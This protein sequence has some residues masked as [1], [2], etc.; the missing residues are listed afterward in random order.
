MFKKIAAL[1]V[2]AIALPAQAVKIEVGAGTAQNDF[3]A[4]SHDLVATI[5]Y[6]AL[7]PAEATGIT[8][9]GVGVFGTY[10]GVDDKD[11]WKDVT[12]DSVDALGLVGLSATKG[13]PFGI[14]VG[15]FYTAIPQ[16]DVKVYG[17]EIRYAFLEG[18]A[19]TPA[20]ALRG[21]I[22][23]VSGIDSF[24]LDSKSLDLSVSKGFGPLTPYAGVGRV[25]GTADPDTGS[26][27]K[28]DVEETR[29]FVGARLGLGLLD[30]IPEYEKIGDNNA[31][32][33]KAGLSF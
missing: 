18:S 11:A 26:L 6:K 29:L 8:G 13:L 33:L 28:V 27:D 31:Y 15:A 32:S 22:S 10:V 12:G 4:I 30:F 23:R 7:G 20:L 19:V 14:D 9:I 5:N 1:A 24:D 25:W 16:G 3:D 2:L 17:A 21:A